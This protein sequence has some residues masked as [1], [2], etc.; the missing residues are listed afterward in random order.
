VLHL[1]LLATGL[2]A[3][4]R[5]DVKRLALEHLAVHLG[6]CLAGLLVLREADEAETTRLASGVHHD[7]AGRDGAELSE[8]FVELL[9]RDGLVEVLDVQVDALVLLVALGLDGIE[10]LLK[11]TL[12]VLLALGLADVQLLLLGNNSLALKIV[13]RLI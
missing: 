5:G 3:L 12:A 13:E 8:L 11:L 4:R 2:L 10:L 6:E 1:E 9:L 7:L